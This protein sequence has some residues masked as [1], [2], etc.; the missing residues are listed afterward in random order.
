[1]VDLRAARLAAG[2]SQTALGER[3]G[4]SQATI[5]AYESG[6]KRPSTAVLERLLGTMGLELRVVE[7][8]G[9]RTAADLHRAG[10][11]LSEALALAEAL[12]FRRAATLAYPRL[13]VA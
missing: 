6:R 12:P 3:A 4:T 7:I 9:R 8:P 2:L 10:R 5:S 13:P 1:M 11:H